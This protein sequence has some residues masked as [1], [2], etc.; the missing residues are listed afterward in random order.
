MRIL[1]FRKALHT[2]RPTKLTVL[3]SLF[4]FLGITIYFIQSIV[5]AQT[6]NLSSLNGDTN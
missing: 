6:H 5:C 2:K 1:I 3:L 4:T